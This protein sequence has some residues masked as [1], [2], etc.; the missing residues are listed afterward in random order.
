MDEVNV[1]MDDVSVK[2]DEVSLGPGRVRETG[3]PLC[4]GE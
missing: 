1:K 2:V 3:T 4:S